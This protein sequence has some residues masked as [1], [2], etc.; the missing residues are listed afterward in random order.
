MPGV[1][2][3]PSPVVPVASGGE[4]LVELAV[5]LRDGTLPDVALVDVACRT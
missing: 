2:C 1:C 5:R 4:A 3:V